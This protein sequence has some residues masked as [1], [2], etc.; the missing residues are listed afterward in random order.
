MRAIYILSFV[1]PLSGFA[2][3]LPHI[4]LVSREGLTAHLRITNS[5]DQVAFFSP[6]IV[7]EEFYDKAACG[8][9]AKGWIATRPRSLGKDVSVESGSSYKFDTPTSFRPTRIT[10][11]YAPT[12]VAKK[13]DYMPVRIELPALA[14]PT[15]GPRTKNEPPAEPSTEE[16]RK[17][18][19]YNLRMIAAAGDQCLLR[20]GISSADMTIISRDFPDEMNKILVAIDGEDYS[21]L[22]YTSDTI[23]SVET[24]T[25][26]T[27]KYPEK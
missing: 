22:V 8:G 5:S 15:G 23:L 3:E 25:L 2:V 20:H 26:G 16:K 6:Y 18:I 24:K 1:I 12:T 9:C 21:G 13:D 17:K 14:R 10:V 7:I 19:A 4:E 27:I 11:F